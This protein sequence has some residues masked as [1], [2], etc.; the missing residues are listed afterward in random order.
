M[1]AWG[2]APG[3][4]IAQRASAESATQCFNESRRQR[5]GVFIYRFPGALPEA[6]IEHCAF[7]A[8]HTHDRRRIE[9]PLVTMALTRLCK[10]SAWQ[11][12][13]RYSAPHG[14]QRLNSHG[15]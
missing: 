3:L 6:M 9:L 10:A 1:T 7:G 2:S 11:A 4:H 8:K 15:R 14:S 13:R 12:E 5:Q